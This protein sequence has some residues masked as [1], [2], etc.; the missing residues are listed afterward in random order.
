[1]KNLKI[2]PI[3]VATLNVDKSEFTYMRNFGVK[4][5]VPCIIWYIQGADKKIMVDTGPC[6]PDWSNRYHFPMIR[7]K[8]QVPLN[9]M[10]KVG[11]DPK[12]IDIVILSHLH[13]DHAFNNHLFPNAI[14]YVQKEEL[15]YAIAPLPVHMKGYESVAIGMSPDYITKTK[16]TIINGDL[17]IVPGVSVVLTPGHSPGSMCVKVETSKGP[18]LIASDTLPLFENWNNPVAHIPR[19]PGAIHVGL[20]EYFESLEK[21]GKITD[22]VLPGH[23]PLV[24]DKTEYP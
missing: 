9:A 19:L 15:K 2:I 7:S 24:F 8:E 10:K 5:E 17:E 14:F 13:W 4:L 11:L 3:N 22:L 20:V 6:D 18:Y 12:E 23:D 16:Y 21:M 1:L